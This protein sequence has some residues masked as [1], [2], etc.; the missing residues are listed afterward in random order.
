MKNK[1]ALK[2][3]DITLDNLECGQIYENN[4]HFAM[5][6]RCGLPEKNDN[7]L[8]LISLTDGNRHEDGGVDMET[9]FGWSRVND[10]SVIEIIVGK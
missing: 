2:N 8:R 6:V 10:K 4:G 1:V 3:G 9:L 7:G 5:I